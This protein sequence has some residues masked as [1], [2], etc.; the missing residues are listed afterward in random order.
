MS[1]KRLFQLVA[2]EEL[3][4]GS[5]A[6]TLYDA[7]NANFLV[8]DPTLEFNPEQFDR[9]N[10][11]RGSLSPFSPL[12]GVVTGSCSFQLELAGTGAATT[13]PFGLLLEACG[14][15]QDAT[16]QVT[17]G[18]IG[19]GEAF[20]NG[21]LVT[22]S[23]AGNNTAYVVHDT[24]NGETRLLLRGESGAMT[25]GG[26]LTG[27]TSGSTATTSTV[28]TAFGISWTP[29]SIE[30]ISL[31]FAVDAGVNV[32]G[33]VVIGQ[34]SG[35]IG[36]LQ[37]TPTGLTCSVRVLDGIFVNGEDAWN[38]TLGGGATN[39]LNGIIA[40]TT[41]QTNVPAL[42][43][44]VIEDGPAKALLGCRGTFSLGGNIGEAMLFDFEFTG[45][46][47]AITDE[48]TVTGI[49]YTTQVPPVMLGV[50]FDIWDDDRADG[51]TPTGTYSPRF[52]APSFAYANSVGIARDAGESTGVY[53]S[54]HITSRTTSG[55]M[56]VDVVPEG[57]FAFI[58]AVSAGTPTHMKLQVGS[59]VGNK[60]I[61]STPSAVFTGEGGGETEGIATRDLPFRVGSRQPDGTDADDCELII[62]YQHTT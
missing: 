11:N 49:T 43:M 22:D 26:V 18:A 32:I 44:A 54:A 8:I 23:G 36:I 35:A 40:A 58:E 9:A 62:T 51:G 34:T 48:G 59:T 20:F 25:N 10:I 5:A 53:G 3:Q 17:I 28:S 12:A 47:N 46:K 13:P 31:S 61:I 27:S 29:D 6:A 2:K 19:V 50:T 56:T 15:R 39:M 42:S 60:F 33:D 55:N 38:V 30:L 41:T 57:A 45:L 1:L 16:T 52:S 24:Y 14:M 7:A 21:E 4:A 37:E